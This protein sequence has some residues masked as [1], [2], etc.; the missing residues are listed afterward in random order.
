LKIILEQEFFRT[1]F[2]AGEIKKKFAGA[3]KEIYLIG[4]PFRFRQ[5]Q[6]WVWYRGF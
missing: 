1:P 4:H 2:R 6:N 5:Y 3:G